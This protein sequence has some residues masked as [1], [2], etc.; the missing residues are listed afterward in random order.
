MRE[1]TKN[2]IIEYHDNI[3]PGASSRC[4]EVLDAAGFRCRT[5]VHPCGEGI[6]YA[7]RA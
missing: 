2:A 6:I 3:C 4:R 1:A 7:S 5:R